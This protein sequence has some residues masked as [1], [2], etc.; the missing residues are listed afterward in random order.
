MENGYLQ[1]HFSVGSCSAQKDKE[2]KRPAPWAQDVSIT[3]WRRGLPL[4]DV[5]N[6]FSGSLENWSGLVDTW[7]ASFNN[8]NHW[9][10]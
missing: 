2:F 1:V 6:I 5:V 7:V 4:N 3:A 10:H 9:H 8:I